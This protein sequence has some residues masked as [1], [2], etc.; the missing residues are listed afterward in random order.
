MARFNH[1]L[2][3]TLRL[4]LGMSQEEAAKT[5][6]VDVRTYRRYEAGTVN[7]GRGFD[8]RHA[9]RRALLRRMCKQ[10]GVADEEAWLVP[11]EVKPSSERRSGHKAA[12]RGHVLQRAKNFVG[13][14]D[15]LARLSTF[16]E[17][18]AAIWVVVGVGGSGKTSVVERFVSTLRT[19]VWVHSFYDDPRT[20]SAVEELSRARGPVVVL[21]GLE[22]VQSTGG[23]GRAFGELDDPA[24]RRALR[25]VCSGLVSRKVLATSR[26]PLSD[27]EAWE[28]DRLTTLPLPP[29]AQADALDLLRAW[30]LSGNDAELAPIHERTGGHALS[31]A[32]V[33]SYVGT[34]FGGDAR[35]AREIPDDAPSDDHTARRLA[36]VLDSYAH[37]LAPHERQLLSRLS[38]FAGAA[39]VPL[40]ASLSGSSDN[41]VLVTTARLE[42][43]GLVA[44]TRAGVSAHPFVREHFKRLLGSSAS[45][46]HAK[47]SDVIASTLEGKPSA[48]VSSPD[49]LDRYE[50]LLLHTL[51]GGRQH[52]AWGIYERA[53]G[54]F[55]NLGLRLGAMTRGARVLASFAEGN[56]PERLDPALE[57]TARTSVLYDWALYAG[58]LGDLR[59][60][61]RCHDAHLRALD[62]I[63]DDVAAPFRAMGLRTAPT[64][65][66]S[67]GSWTSPAATSTAHSKSRARWTTSGLSASTSRAA[68]R[69]APWSSTT[70]GTSTLRCARST[71]CASSKGRR[72]QGGR[73]GRQ[74]SGSR[75]AITRAR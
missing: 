14:G 40:L 58:A 1:E 11:S 35:Y 75:V 37:S 62:D 34:F 46:A 6:R 39:D 12:R 69:C 8:V 19:G 29:L 41:E 71:P 21:D 20:E 54:G 59:L 66:G 74:R 73:S 32:M 17:G 68:W 16:V 2:L 55:E 18:D 49:L 25:A 13:R 9:S 5:L 24:L 67:L 38:L 47:I 31:L 28:G 64:S 70:P 30:G 4:D 53:L 65:P 63:R 60:A 27:L 3:R 36:S 51:R 43:L 56:A 7:A 23:N 44:R 61:A 15:I 22:A 52:D 45:S 26:F 72:P 50:T 42:R 33:G 10:L 48:R 57:G